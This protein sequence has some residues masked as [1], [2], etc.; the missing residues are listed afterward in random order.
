LLHCR[1][2]AALATEYAEGKL[3]GPR[4]LALRFHLLLCS[5]CRLFLAQLERTRARLAQ[6]GDEPVSRDP[7]GSRE[8]E[9]LEALRAGAPKV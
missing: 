6:L 1:D 8:A 5:A 4:R 3:S 9:F 7:Q 2:V